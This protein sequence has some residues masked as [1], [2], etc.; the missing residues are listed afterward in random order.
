V[1][2][3]HEPE[4]ELFDLAKDPHEMVNVYHHPEYAA[5][6]QTLTA[7]LH[8]LQVEVGDQPYSKDVD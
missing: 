8:R 3:T 5:T 1:D 6:A 7:E 4:W 2:E